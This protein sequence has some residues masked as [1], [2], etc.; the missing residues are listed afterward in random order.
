MEET[1]IE[2][3]L[4]SGHKRGWGLKLIRTIMDDVRIERI[5]DRTRVILVKNIKPNEVL[6]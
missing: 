4:H 6:K 5:D 3:K 1:T 2:E